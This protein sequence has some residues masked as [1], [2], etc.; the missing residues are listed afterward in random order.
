MD[1][2]CQCL[3]RGVDAQAH[4]TAISELLCTLAILGNPP[5]HIYPPEHLGLAE[6]IVSNEGFLVTEFLPD[7]ISGPITLRKKPCDWGYG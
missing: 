6:D 5:Q 4:K 1:G 7:V 3:A 2:G